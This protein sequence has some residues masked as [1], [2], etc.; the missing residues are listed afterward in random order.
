[1]VVWVSSP[2]GYM[3][4]L[5]MIIDH[6]EVSIA[7]IRTF[8]QILYHTSSSLRSIATMRVLLYLQ[9][10]WICMMIGQR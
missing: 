1:M 2:T 3:L 7:I 6:H 9:H 4:I 10:P 8:H 5:R